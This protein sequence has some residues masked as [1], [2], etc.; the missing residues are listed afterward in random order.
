MIDKY[1]IPAPKTGMISLVATAA[2][3]RK[4]SIKGIVSSIGNVKYIAIATS[5]ITINNKVKKKLPV[6][7][8]VI[9]SKTPPM[10]PVEFVKTIFLIISFNKCHNQKDC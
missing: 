2:A 7:F 4:G 10:S 8:I 3:K 6:T 1:I 5:M 9:E